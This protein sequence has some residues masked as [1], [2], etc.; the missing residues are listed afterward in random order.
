[1]SLDDEMRSK[2]IGMDAGATSCV[3]L[4]T[5]SKIICANSGDSRAVLCKKESEAIGLSEDHKPE[6][7]QEMKRIEAAGHYV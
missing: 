5:E 3:V 4:I 7:P 1:M 6:N 2:D